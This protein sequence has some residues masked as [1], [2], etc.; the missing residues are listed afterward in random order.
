MTPD[1]G[2]DRRLVDDSVDDCCGW[3]QFVS[4]AD[5]P[6]ALLPEA[7]DGIVGRFDSFVGSITEFGDVNC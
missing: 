3:R 2:D 1:G 7:G 6:R 4:S 5:L